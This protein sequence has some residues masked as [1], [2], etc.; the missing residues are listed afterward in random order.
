MS[1][2]VGTTVGHISPPSYD[3]AASGSSQYSTTPAQLPVLGP[4]SYPSAG[5]S[6][7]GPIIELGNASSGKSVMVI[8]M[9]QGSLPSSHPEHV[10]GQC[11]RPDIAK[12]MTV[13]GVQYSNLDPGCTI[14]FCEKCNKKVKIRKFM[15]NDLDTQTC[16]RLS[17][18]FG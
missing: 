8:H 5:S 2:R 12:S 10:S 13:E 7:P 14:D 16:F 9:E 17:L 4:P 15:L 18:R 6:N 11:P 1:N 3:Q